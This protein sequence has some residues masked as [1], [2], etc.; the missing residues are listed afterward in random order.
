MTKVKTSQNGWYQPERVTFTLEKFGHPE[1]TYETIKANSLLYGELD[2]LIKLQAR[3]T[4]G[5]ETA[6]DVVGQLV[7]RLF[8]GDWNIP[9]PRT[10]EALKPPKEDPESYRRLPTEVLLEMIR[11]TMA[12]E[13]ILPE[14]SGGKS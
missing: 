10:G 8:V 12:G 7:G 2:D 1:F 5:D 11:Q 13:E 9:D 6:T 3:I 4:R 14:A